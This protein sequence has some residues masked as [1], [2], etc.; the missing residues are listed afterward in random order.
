MPISADQLG[1]LTW[2]SFWRCVYMFSTFLPNITTQYRVGYIQFFGKKC[3]F[4]KKC[5]K[6]GIKMPISADQLGRLTWNSLWRCVYMFS[7]FLLNIT[8]RFPVVYIQFFE[9]KK[10]KTAV[11]ESADSS[12]V[13]ILAKKGLKMTQFQNSL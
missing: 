5:R 10:L 13:T 6:I 9:R 12:H 3:N 1:R 8:T 7:T 4:R 2:N 11:F